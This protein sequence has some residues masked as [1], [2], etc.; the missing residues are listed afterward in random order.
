MTDTETVNPQVTDGVTHANVTVLASTPAFALAQSELAFAQSQGVLFANMVSGQ[1]QQ[2][3][4][5]SAA[6]LKCVK[7]LLNKSEAASQSTHSVM[8]TASKETFTDT[9]AEKLAVY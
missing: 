4:A 9:V 5:G 1:Q 3:I 2:A 6:A 8:S 7:Q